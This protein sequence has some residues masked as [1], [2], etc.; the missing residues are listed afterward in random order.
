MA[1]SLPTFT[2]AAVVLALASP[3][4]AQNKYADPELT[5]RDRDHWAFKAPR[6]QP[7]PKVEPRLK[8]AGA[9]G[10]ITYPLNK[11]IP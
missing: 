10:I 2:L 4:A 8:R 3:G 9:T 6:R 11:V 7:V 1:R 5:P